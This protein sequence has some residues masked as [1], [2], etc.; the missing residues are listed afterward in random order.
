MSPEILSSVEL[1]F[2]NGELPMENIQYEIRF[3]EI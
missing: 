3:L 1:S 2:I